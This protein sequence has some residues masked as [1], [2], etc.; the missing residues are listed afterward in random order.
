MTL[1]IEKQL[2]T[3]EAYLPQWREYAM[4]AQRQKQARFGPQGVRDHLRAHRA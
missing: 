2:L 3:V 4:A 1:T